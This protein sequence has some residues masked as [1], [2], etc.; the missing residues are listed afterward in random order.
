MLHLFRSTVHPGLS[1]KD[2]VKSWHEISTGLRER[3]RRRKL[4]AETLAQIGLS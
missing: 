1:L 3:P 4:Q 2:S